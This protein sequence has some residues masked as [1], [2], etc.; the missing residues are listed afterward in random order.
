[1]CMDLHSDS[2]LFMGN[3]QLRKYVKLNLL[4]RNGDGCPE[5]VTDLSASYLSDTT[6]GSISAVASA[7]YGGEYGG[8]HG[9]GLSHK[10]F[11]VE[12]CWSV[13][14]IV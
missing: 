7:E 5:M 10:P 9:P 3:L 2:D 4:K 11:N 1:M 13:L 12:R 14:L 8:D 6:I